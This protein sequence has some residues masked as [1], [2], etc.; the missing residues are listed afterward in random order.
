[1]QPCIKSREG[2]R[3]TLSKKREAHLANMIENCAS[4]CLFVWEVWCLFAPRASKI[5][6]TLALPLHELFPSECEAAAVDSWKGT[7]LAV[8]L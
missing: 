5:F 1:M 4:I 3:V 2:I 7:K 6:L 8:A